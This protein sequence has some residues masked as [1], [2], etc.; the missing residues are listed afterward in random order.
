MTVVSKMNS[1]QSVY[2]SCQIAALYCDWRPAQSCPHLL[3]KH[4][5]VGTICSKRTT[6]SPFKALARSQPFIVIGALLIHI[7]FIRK[8]AQVGTICP[9]ILAVSFFTDQA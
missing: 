5:Q 6:I 8:H 2:S 3:G 7:P 9:K 1:C 4:A